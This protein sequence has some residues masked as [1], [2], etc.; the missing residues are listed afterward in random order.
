MPS[1]L[2]ISVRF[3]QDA[4]HGRRDSG[5]P[6]WPPSPNR[7]FQ[8]LVRTA[9]THWND[10][11]FSDRAIPAL[12]WLEGQ[13]APDVVAP[14]TVSGAPYRLSVPNNAMDLVARAWVRGNT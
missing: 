9:A 13:P 6:E 12:E 10:V 7:L 5:E 3:L 14:S 11:E 8:A 2:C 1:F 4:F